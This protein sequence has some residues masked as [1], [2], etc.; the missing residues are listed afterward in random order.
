VAATPYPGR[1]RLRGRRTSRR[2]SYLSVLADNA[3][4]GSFSHP[5]VSRCRLPGPGRVR[6]GCAR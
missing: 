3:E 5:Q 6:A 4:S 1:D 2:M